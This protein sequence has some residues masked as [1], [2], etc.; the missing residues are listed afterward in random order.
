MGVTPRV[1]YNLIFQHCHEN[2]QP[3]LTSLS[4]IKALSHKTSSE[5]ARS[6][7]RNL[8]NLLSRESISFQCPAHSTWGNLQTPAC[9]TSKHNSP[10]YID[11]FSKIT[12]TTCNSLRRSS[13]LQS[14]FSVE[15][16]GSQFH[17]LQTIGM[18]GA[19]LYF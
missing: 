19:P 5:F 14:S 1:V 7:Q 13:L 17:S 9:I 10:R 18:Y 4:L 11:G 8:T 6:L 16:E 3:I 2:H 15:T 12:S